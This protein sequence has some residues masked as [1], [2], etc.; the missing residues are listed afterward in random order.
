MSARR[1]ESVERVPSSESSMNLA[2]F[3]RLFPTNDACLD[4]LRDK[5]YPAGSACPEC[6][7]ATKFHRITGRSAYACQYCR[8][9]VYPTAG[10]IFHKSSTNLTLWFWA[11]FL[12]S[13]TR[14]GISAKQ[15]EREVGVSYKT[16]LR[17]FRQIREML[18]QDETPLSGSVEAD[19]MYVGG[20]AKAYP[21]RTRTEHLARKVPVFGAVERGGRVVAKVMD[22]AQL[23]SVRGNLFRYVVPTSTLYTDESSNYT[24]LDMWLT[25]KDHHRIAH[26]TKVYVDGDVHTQTID[27]FF[28]GTKNAI[29]GVHH[30]VSR[31]H[32]QGYLNEHTFRYNNRDSETPLFWL[33][34]DRVRKDGLAAS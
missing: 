30:G 4:Y 29:R 18:D 19:E 1:K 8:H 20:K 28:A 34:L 25:H 3:M 12:M 17:M 22:N 14:C 21:K 10:T 31:K 6:G 24:G 9:Q 23:A 16:A 2:D 15:L 33:I 13:S 11:I 5:F 32:L 27:G 26:F 7:K